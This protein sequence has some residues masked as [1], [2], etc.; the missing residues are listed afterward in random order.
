MVRKG[1]YLLFLK[2]CF[3]SFS[4][5]ESLGVWMKLIRPVS[6]VLNFLHFKVGFKVTLLLW[7]SFLLCFFSAVKYVCV[8]VEKSRF[9]KSRFIQICLTCELPRFLGFQFSNDLAIAH[10]HNL[11][12]YSQ[13]WLEFINCKA[14]VGFFGCQQGQC[15]DLLQSAELW[16]IKAKM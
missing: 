8:L 12:Y 1:W 15:R 10:N 4:S 11:C 6:S 14:F 13:F 7:R 9:E 5:Y 16:N 3:C 2:N